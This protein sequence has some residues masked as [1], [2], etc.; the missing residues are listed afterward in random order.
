M[1]K[2][3]KLADQ[4]EE[5][6]NLQY[7]KYEYARIAENQTL[8]YGMSNLPF[9]K[10]TTSKDVEGFLIERNGFNIEVFII[11][12]LL[13]P[14]KIWAYMRGIENDFFKSTSDV[15]TWMNNQ[16]VMQMEKK[17]KEK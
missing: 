10:I 14:I 4:F 13:K 2:V 15:I 16:Y 3:K 9:K 11:G 5:Q 8:E 7:G 12:G 17:L 1:T 6:L